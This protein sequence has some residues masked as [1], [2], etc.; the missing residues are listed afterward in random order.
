MIWNHILSFASSLLIHS[1]N[2]QSWPL[3]ITF[4]H[5]CRTSISTFPKLAKE[6]NFQVK[7][8]KIVTDGIVNQAEGIIDDKVS[9]NFLFSART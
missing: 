7:I 3:V 9:F 4:F 8:V 6:N 1:A 2:P 5:T